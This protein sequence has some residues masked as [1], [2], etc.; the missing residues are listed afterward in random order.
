MIDLTGPL[1]RARL[2]MLLGGRP[3]D[4]ARVKGVGVVL[5]IRHESKDTHVE[6][7]LEPNDLDPSRH[8]AMR[9]KLATMVRALDRDVFPDRDRHVLEASRYVSEHMHAVANAWRS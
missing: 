9:T 3:F 8:E 5:T 2:T 7:A 1:T 6:M 4:L